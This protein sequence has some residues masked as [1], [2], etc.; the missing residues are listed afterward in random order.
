MVTFQGECYYTPQE[1]KKQFG[2]AIPTLYNWA[3]T[4]KVKLLSLEAA[5]ADTPFSPDDLKN[6]IYFEHTSL[7]ECIKEL[8]SGKSEYKSVKL[9]KQIRRNAVRDEIASKEC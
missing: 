3:Y 8:R 2:V 7:L 5:C 4:D 6:T 1:A 9:S